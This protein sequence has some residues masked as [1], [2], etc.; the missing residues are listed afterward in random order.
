MGEKR[1]RSSLLCLITFLAIVVGGLFIHEIGHGL[2]A[3]AIGGRISALYVWPGVQVFPHPG[4]A[5]PG[6]WNNRLGAA[7]IGQPASWAKNGW[8]MGFVLLMG[9]GT[10][11]LLGAL[12]L[13]GAWLLK[14]QG[15][16]RCFLFS[17]IVLAV[18]LPCYSLF[19][20]FGLRHYIFIGGWYAEPL[21]GARQMGIP[22]GVFL[23]VTLA[24]SVLMAMWTWK[25][26][27]LPHSSSLK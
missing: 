13:L 14:P 4:Q 6:D 7:E 19:P 17:A 5:F 27:S 1:W 26:Y 8:Q 25:A 9:S 3:S 21:L 12:A 11:F 24:A 18:D 16:L 20:L 10:N 15:W 23:F 22:D 2:A